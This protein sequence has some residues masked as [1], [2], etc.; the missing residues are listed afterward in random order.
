M[1]YSGQRPPR[2]PRPSFSQYSQQPLPQ[3]SP[4]SYI[5]Q[6][7]SP[8]IPYTPP[9]QPREAGHPNVSFQTTERGDRRALL[10][11]PGRV[12]QHSAYQ[13][14]LSPT[15]PDPESGFS[16][17][18]AALIGRKKSLVRPD[19]EKIEPGHRHW[20]YHTHAARLEDTNANLVQPSSV[21]FCPSTP[22]SLM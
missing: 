22:L 21:F 20:H 6:P 16:V 19:R 2:A 15:S 10:D 7:N 11:Q 12:R 17:A 14:V 18:D 1:D 13:N 8:Y 3:N 5:D 9:S 4:P